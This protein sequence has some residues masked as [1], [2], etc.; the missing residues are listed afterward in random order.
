MAVYIIEFG[1]LIMRCVVSELV[2]QEQMVAVSSCCLVLGTAHRTWW[3]RPAHRTMCCGYVWCVV[4]GSHADAL[5]QG[6][7]CCASLGGAAVLRQ[8]PWLQLL[9]LCRS[10]CPPAFLFS[11]W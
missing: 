3:T 7:C 8:V 4:V 5:Q 2:G 1:T 10:V 11:A 6:G 9:S